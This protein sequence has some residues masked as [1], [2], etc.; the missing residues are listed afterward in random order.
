MKGKLAEL[1]F[2]VNKPT[3]LSADLFFFVGVW[4][5]TVKRRLQLNGQGNMSSYLPLSMQKKR[6]MCEPRPV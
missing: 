2:G 1:A 3:M 4:S 5:M 6:D